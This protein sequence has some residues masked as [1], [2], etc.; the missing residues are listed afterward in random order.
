MI[1]NVK[2]YIEPFKTLN[3]PVP[4][5]NL[6]IY[7]FKIKEYYNFMLSIDILMQEKDKV[8][9]IDIIQMSYLEYIVKVLFNDDTF[10]SEWEENN[11]SIWK[12]KFNTIFTNSLQCEIT[13]INFCLDEKGKLFLF[14]KGNKILAKHFNDLIKIILYL[15]IANYDDEYVSPDVQE[16]VDKYFQQQPNKVHSPSLNKKI[17]FVVSETGIGKNEILNMNIIE[18]EELYNLTLE[19]FDYKINRTA[20]LSGNVEFKEKLEHFM[21]KKPKTI[22]DTIFQ[23]SQNFEQKMGM[24]KQNNKG[25]I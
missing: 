17:L 10:N 20:E 2:Q 16:V 22:Y 11:S 24:N 6:L 1:N 25:E 18:F 12:K 5:K 14:I 8:N 21:F 15:N 23:S 19:K 3:E 4:Y 9:N 13:D 7:P